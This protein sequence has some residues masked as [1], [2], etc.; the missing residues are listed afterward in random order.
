MKN[1]FRVCLLILACALALS[2][3]AAALAAPSAPRDMALVYVPLPA[4]DALDRFEAT[5]LPIFAQEEAAGGA[6]V[7]AG[8][9]PDGLRRLAAAGLEYR[10]LDAEMAGATYYFALI[11]PGRPQP[12]WSAY[13]VV[14][15]D[16]EQRL[17]RATPAHAERLAE[18]GVELAQLTLAPIALQ[19]AEAVPLAAPAAITPD[20]LIRGMI[21]QVASA[22]VQGYVAQLS[23]ETPVT[24]GGAPYTIVTRHTNSGTAI[25]KATQFAGEHLAGLGLAV[26]YH[27]W[28]QSGYTNRNV[29]GQLT[30]ATN[31]G[32]IYIIGAH[33]DDMPSGPTAPGADDNASGSAATL[34]AADILSR[35]RWGCTL[36][37]AF[38]TGEEQGL[39]GSDVYARRAKTN[40]ETIK[41]YL[42]LDML[43]YNGTSPR[44]VDLYYKVIP[45][46]SEQI[47]D[48]FV[49]VVGA[50]GLDLVPL[51]YNAATHT[52][53]NQSD[54]KSFWTQGY[55]AILAI[56]DYEGGD[57]TPYYHKVTDRLAT[58]DL[59]YLT[60]FVKAAV[61]AFVH[62]NNCLLTGALDGEVT[63]SHSD[64]AIV[65]ASVAMTDTHGLAYS[66]STDA[67]GRYAATL[68]AATYDMTASAY[69]YLPATASG[70]VLPTAG[71]TQSFVLQ[72][73]PP[74]APDVLVEV[75][76]GAVQLTWTH[77]PP[78]MTYR[79]HRA[80][81]PYFTPTVGNMQATFGL[82]FAT[83]V[84]Y[85]DPTSGVGD[86]LLNHFYIV[87]GRNAAGQEALSK[88]VGEFDFT[89]IPGG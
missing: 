37:F 58:L 78:N 52:T 40:G 26:E 64:T 74:A 22:A 27:N 8:A 61:G 30:G 38:W 45:A 60:T 9:G 87:T 11:P 2:G 71:A 67:T 50:Y 46:G 13:G 12:A 57:F 75:A 49:G 21:D 72:A 54:N 48:T 53:G 83:P 62:M 51:K 10:I 43:G 84:R 73:A 32:D 88:R 68:P 29:I 15:L 47:A 77:L 35:Y 65:G 17:I 36:R 5:G 41:G 69:G 89:L 14:L 34:I 42:N 24:V 4:D 20:P 55:P 3:A 19:R 85:A 39:L 66:A 6:Y 86:P 18:Q 81:A 16:G 59:D 70:V 33:L 25:Q 82:P 7:L 76:D 79:V 31:P 44:N 63:A 23:G 80:T 56:E 1:R 28:S